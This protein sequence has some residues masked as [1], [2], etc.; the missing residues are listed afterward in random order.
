MAAQ[1]T[2]NTCRNIW[3][4]GRNYGEHAKELGHQAPSSSTDPMIFLKAGS[5][6]VAP[7]A[8]FALPA[9]SGDVHH[10]L[11]VAF[12][13]DKNLNLT[14]ISLALDLTARDVQNRLKA[15]GHPWSLAKTFRA[16]CPIGPFVTIPQGLNLEDIHFTL[17]VNSELRQK[18]HTRDMIHP[19][20]K[21]RAYVLER[22]PVEP[23]DILLTG[24]PVGVA[25]LHPGD[26]LEAEIAGV[27]KTNWQV[28][29][30]G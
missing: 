10:E 29:A 25:R 11:E 26:R 28:T 30:N 9:F 23:G 22:F 7:G 12:R 13:F 6:L 1:Q 16:S 3:A 24:T 19:V 4:V 2:F 8:S 21:L 5:S 18:G 17:H 20:E 15:Q 14:E 27:V